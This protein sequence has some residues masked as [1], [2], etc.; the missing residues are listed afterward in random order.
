MG[1]LFFCFSFQPTLVF[2]VSL[3]FAKVAG[4]KRSGMQNSYDMSESSEEDWRSQGYDKMSGWKESEMEDSEEESFDMSESSEEDWWSD[5]HAKH[6]TRRRLCPKFTLGEFTWLNRSWIGNR[7]EL[8]FLV[9]RLRAPI[10][11]TV[12]G[13]YYLW[14]SYICYIEGYMCLDL[15]FDN[16]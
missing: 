11:T 14:F 5:G 9:Y 4:W 16:F 3:L 1:H 2:C 12:L 7:S 8:S 6:W 15:N 13:R 10:E